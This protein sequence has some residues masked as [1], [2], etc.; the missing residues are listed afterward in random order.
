MKH[1]LT[2]FLLFS[3]TLLTAQTELIIDNFDDQELVFNNFSGNCG[4]WQANGPVIGRSFETDNPYGGAGACLKL[5]YNVPGT[6]GGCGYWT[7]MISQVDS[8]YVSL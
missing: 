4:D 5:H 1:L 8:D 3:A 2:I 7:S 6:S